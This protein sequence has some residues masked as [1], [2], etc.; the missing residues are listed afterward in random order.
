MTKPLYKRTWFMILMFT[1]IVLAII[2][3]R[4][5]KYVI[6][7]VVE[8]IEKSRNISCGE[9]GISLIAGSIQLDSVE[10]N[11]TL[12]GKSPVVLKSSK[13]HFKNL[14][15]WDYLV[16]NEITISNITLE[17]LDFLFA[18]SFPKKAKTQLDTTD[19]KNGPTKLVVHSINISQGKVHTSNTNSRKIDIESF[20]AYINDFT[21]FHLNDSTSVDLKSVEVSAYNISLDNK[22]RK[23]IVSIGKF[24]LSDDENLLLRNLEWSPR[25]SKDIFASSIPYQ[26]S[27]I[28]LKLP[29]LEAYPFSIKKFIFNDDFT[30][31]NVNIDNGR[32]EAV[33]NKLHVDCIDCVKKYFYEGL[34]SLEYKI[35][36]NAIK[37]NNAEIVYSQII[38]EGKE[39]GKLNWSK[40]NADITDLS[41]VKE[42]KREYAVFD[43][44]A[45]FLEN[46][47]LSIHF[48]FPNVNPK[49]K[50]TF[51]GNLDKLELNELNDFLN[52]ASGF[53]IKSG[54]LD[55]LKFY[56]EGDLQTSSGNMEL[57][58]SG[59]DIAVLSEDQ[60]KR[61]V[62]TALLN[63]ILSNKNNPDEKD[64]L[65]VGEMYFERLFEKRFIGNI[66]NTLQTGIRSTVLPNLLLPEELDVSKD[67]TRTLFNPNNKSIIEV[68]SKRE[69][70]R[71][72]RR[73]KK[74]LEK[75][76]SN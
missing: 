45:S 58:Y 19:T 4:V 3:H 26:K 51:A 6:N 49:L 62:L 17:N 28:D 38:E 61:K 12:N 74:A 32:L 55:N 37:I 2:F 68:K 60:K 71:E 21:Y 72:K 5:K 67:Q 9:V 27:W 24:E 50:Y 48:R 1:L 14:S 42:S 65:R 69:I 33:K 16:N 22:R 47:N 53:S 59:L 44:D 56:G 20:E 73:K 15:Y 52:F 76:E 35:D 57:K 11:Y 36:L 10:V 54:T 23:N 30:P 25:K 64:K 18:S 40:I 63:S 39:T 70:R 66:W 31:T 43:I 41:N 7:E 46:N 29:V 75:N 8:K 34:A 13:A